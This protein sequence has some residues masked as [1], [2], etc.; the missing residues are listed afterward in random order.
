MAL[1]DINECNGNHTCDHIC[2]NTVGSYYCSCYSGFILQSDN[3]KCEGLQC[4]VWYSKLVTTV[5]FQIQ[6]S[7]HIITIIIT[8]IT[9]IITMDVH[10]N[11]LTLLDHITVPAGMAMS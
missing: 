1:K 5:K 3:R 9:I 11:V 2:I 8:I 4:N 10:K 7:V 6:M